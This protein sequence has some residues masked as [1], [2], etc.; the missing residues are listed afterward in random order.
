MSKHS[1]IIGITGKPGSGKSF[2]ADYIS[3]E[4]GIEVIKFDKNL[5]ELFNSK[6][7]STLLGNKKMSGHRIYY[8]T[9]K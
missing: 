8:R 7:M 5:D 4:T 9:L 2:F 3:K 1:N 6:I